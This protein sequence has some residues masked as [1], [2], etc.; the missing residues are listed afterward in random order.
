VLP[1]QRARRSVQILKLLLVERAAMSR[2][3]Q[4]NKV[5][6]F[7]PMRTELSTPPTM[8]LLMQQYGKIVIPMEI[9]ARD[10]FAHLTPEKL[11]RKLQAGYIPLPIVR[12]DES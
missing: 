10:F 9:V 5:G 8:H 12:M 3:E 2:D 1:R 11:R 4:T 7:G 6:A